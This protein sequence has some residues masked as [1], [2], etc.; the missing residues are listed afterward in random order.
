MQ[1][2]HRPWLFSAT[3]S[4]LKWPQRDLLKLYGGWWGSASVINIV[5]Q[6]RHSGDK[7]ETVHPQK[8]W[9]MKIIVLIP[10]QLRRCGLGWIIRML[11]WWSSPAGSDLL[12]VAKN[13]FPVDGQCIP[14]EIQVG[15]HYQGGRHLIDIM[16]HVTFKHL[17]HLFKHSGC[18]SEWLS[19][20]M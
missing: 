4:M 19:H 1:P 8:K 14:R 16:E 6:K 15:Y 17:V 18:W 20:I 2:T 12:G 13:I 5:Q 11:H 9:W 7:G 10:P 3:I